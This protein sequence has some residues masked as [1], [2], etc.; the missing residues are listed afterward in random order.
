MK[1]RQQLQQQQKTSY[2]V[3]HVEVSEHCQGGHSFCVKGKV[4]QCEMAKGK[5]EFLNELV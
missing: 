1:K 2:R 5:K 4:F 3:L